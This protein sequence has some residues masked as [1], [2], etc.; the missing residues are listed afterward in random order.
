MPLVDKDAIYLKENLDVLFI[1][2]NPPEQSNKN[3]HYFSGSKSSFYKQLYLSVLISKELDKLDA[4]EVVFGG[5]NYNYKNKNY[6][7][8]DLLPDLVETKGSKVSVKKRDIELMIDRIFLYKPKIVCVM[9]SKVK[10]RLS[11]YIKTNLIYGYNGKL[12]D[13][14][15]TQFYCNYFPNGNNISTEGKVNIYKE[16]RDNL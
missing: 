8:I 13:N 10:N 16:I 4:D 15:D 1:A 3:G 5:N 11:K 12:F 9:H 6:G 2:L 14:L 7:V